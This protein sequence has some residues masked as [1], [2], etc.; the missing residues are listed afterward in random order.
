M[1][2]IIRTVEEIRTADGTLTVVAEIPTAAT[3]EGGTATLVDITTMDPRTLQRQPRQRHLVQ[4]PHRPTT[5]HNTHSTMLASQ[6]EILMQ[7]MEAMRI[8]LPTT[9]TT[10]NSRLSNQDKTRLHRHRQVVT[11]LH[12]LHQ[13]LL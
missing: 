5:R 3:E 2:I 13:G 6:A 11:R 12:R 8:M 1:Q 7:P 10:H 4:L 9:N